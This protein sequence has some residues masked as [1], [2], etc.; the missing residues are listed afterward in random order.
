MRKTKILL[1]VTLSLVIVTLLGMLL[2]ACNSSSQQERQIT[3][4]FTPGKTRET[5]LQ[6]ESSEDIPIQTETAVIPP[7]DQSE[8]TAVIPVQPTMVVTNT[9]GLPIIVT[10]TRA[11]TQPNQPA[12]TAT[13]TKKPATSTAT[14]TQK[15]ATSTVTATQK[16][17]NTPTPTKTLTP[18]A[19]QE[20]SKTA[21]LTLAPTLQSGWEGEW[22]TYFERL[23]GSIGVGTLEFTLQGTDMTAVMRLDNLDYLF[24]GIIFNVG[25]YATGSWSSPNGQGYFWWNLQENGQFRGCHENH[26]AFCGSRSGIDQPSPCLELPSR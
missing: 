21:T 26:Y 14:A 18:T 10:Q 22:V 7:A 6:P 11:A 17:S 25:K 2:F 23:D 15:P 4:A 13:P 20:P 5:I 24:D 19:T 3:N 8:P 1:P 12:K 9:Q 16:P